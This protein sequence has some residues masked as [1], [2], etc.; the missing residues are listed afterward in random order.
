MNANQ[1]WE[2]LFFTMWGLWE[3]ARA[4]E[5]G[6][7]GL[8]AFGDGFVP[9]GGGLDLALMGLAAGA[10]LGRCGLLALLAAA[11]NAAGNGVL[12]GGVRWLG[13]KSLPT[14]PRRVRTIF[15]RYGLGCVAVAALVPFVPLPL[16][17]LV[18]LAAL[19]PGSAAR[20]V[21][22]VGAMRVPRYLLLV[23]LGHWGGRVAGGGMGGLGLVVALA[24]AA[25]LAGRLL[26]RRLVA[27]PSAAVPSPVLPV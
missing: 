2:I 16:K 15:E 22:V 23:S 26:Y 17:L 21:G 12:F 25:S 1:N 6:L 18:A 8:A 19:G 20:F 27:G 11:A 13:S 10:S 3:A 24:L 14:F 4:S 5:A 7:L 9:L